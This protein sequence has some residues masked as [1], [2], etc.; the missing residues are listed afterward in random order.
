MWL[1]LFMND[2][3][4]LG[5]S[6]VT[7]K[8]KHNLLE[9]TPFSEDQYKL[10]MTLSYHYTILQ[11]ARDRLEKIILSFLTLTFAPLGIF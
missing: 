6:Q 5:K 2:N 8:K 3:F 9:Y 4:S 11:R 1:K 7:S 10:L